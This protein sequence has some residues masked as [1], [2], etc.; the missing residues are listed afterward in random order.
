M[1]SL[2][3]WLLGALWLQVIAPCCPLPHVEQ[4]EVVFPLR[5]PGPRARRALP[6]HWGLYP[7][8]VSYLLKAEEHSFTVHLRKNRE[9]LGSGYMETYSA[10]NGSEVT[11]K[12]Q[13]QDHCLYQG[14]VEGHH[15]SAA[16]LSIC[17][18]LRGFFRVGSAIHLIEPLDESGEEGQHAVYQAKHLQQKSG[19]C[20]VNNTILDSVLGPRVSGAFRPQP[21]PLSQ[22]IHYVELYVVTDSKELQ[23]LGSREAV[24]RR[25]LEVVNHVDKLYQELNFR[26]VLVGLEIWSR[27]KILISPKANITLDNFL[28]WQA[29]ALMGQHLYDNVQLI[30]A[31]KFTGTTVGLAKVSTMCSQYSGAVNEDHHDNPIGVASTMAHEL[32]HNLG[33]NHDENIQGC[34]CPV[35]Q[36]D[37]GCIMAGSIGS[38]F[39]RTFSWC[40]RTDLENF[41][42]GPQVGCLSNAPDVNQ[43]V[44][45][46]V[47]GNLFVERGEQ[48]D[49][50][51]PQHC[52][53]HCC[54]A[55]TCQL[56]EGAECAH[57]DCCHECRVKPAGQP[58][59]SPKDMCDLEESCDGQQPMCPE[60]TFQEN[61]TP[62]PGGYC[63]NGKCPTIAHRCQ[64]LWG[65][66]E[67]ANRCGILY[68][69][70]TQL[71]PDRTSCT[72]STYSGPCQALHTGS[73]GSAFETVLDGTKCDEGKV[74]WEG[75]C[76][77]LQVYRSKNCSA[78]CNNHGVCNHKKECH[79]HA[80]WA[81]PH[82][83]ERLEHVH[84]ASRSLL[85]TIPLVVA[86]LIVILAAVILY[87]K[88]SS[89]F[90]RRSSTP[91]TTVGLSNPV[92]REQGSNLPTKGKIP[93]H[94][95]LIRTTPPS[96]PASPSL[97]PKRPPPAPPATMSTPP[98]PVPVYTQQASD[99]LRPPPPAK[100]LPVLKSKPVTKPTFAPP[101]PPAKPG[102]TQCPGNRDPP[103]PT[104]CPGNGAPA[105]V[106]LFLPSA[107]GLSLASRP[108]RCAN[109]AAAGRAPAPPSERRRARDFRDGGA[110][111]G[112]LRAYG[113][114]RRLPAF[115][116]RAAVGRPRAHSCCERP[117]PPGTRRQGSGQ[118]L[119]LSTCSS[120]VGPSQSWDP[121]EGAW[122]HLARVR[123]LL[124]DK[125]Q[126]LAILQEAVQDQRDP[127][128]FQPEALLIGDP[129]CMKQPFLS[130][131]S[132]AK[133]LAKIPS[134]PDICNDTVEG[135]G[136]EGSAAGLGLPT[137]PVAAAG[138]VQ[139]HAGSR[140]STVIEE[141]LLMGRDGQT[142]PAGHGLREPDQR[143]VVRVDFHELRDAGPTRARGRWSI[144]ASLTH[145]CVVSKV[146]TPTWRSRPPVG[147]AAE[148]GGGPPAGLVQGED[149]TESPSL[150]ASPPLGRSKLGG[151]KAVLITS[152]LSQHVLPGP[153]GTSR[154]C[155]FRAEELAL[156]AWERGGG[157]SIKPRL[158]SGPPHG[159]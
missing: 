30:T 27:D 137:G 139:G 66:G 91:K 155:P 18:G 71:H 68:C 147:A 80:G 19:T 75:H 133:A 146:S 44:G 102:M 140:C 97:T 53:N 126:A 49:C 86:L 22:K 122:E 130:H 123:Q 124:E 83:T 3:L 129:G 96:Q 25:V 26:V 42:K 47:C 87:R 8:S 150:P 131:V 149:N 112:T 107:A 95:E 158:P 89:R 43:L 48:C 35:P 51:E 134:Q 50:G 57:G 152:A 84:K 82:C 52:A 119:N 54:N 136:L 59:R 79:C 23:R 90:Q 138:D 31:V 67:A 105:L 36:T 111:A 5:L 135:L 46:P 17:K 4:Y 29:K 37:G 142:S 121:A 120:Q 153:K 99:Q 77:D 92:F 76:Q 151:P 16:S 64:E 103:L 141:P 143:R 157:G 98:L 69:V 117:R 24:R 159:P 7:E 93:G 115:P 73:S 33:L 20:G 1:L 148:V 9:L 127:L 21:W 114:R 113:H 74:C 10:T 132:P 108:A 60:D 85:F 12:L 15:G 32:G 11:E 145:T 106:A 110:G 65:T 116:R 88:A 72:I 63:F 101:T 40:S 118:T 39:P 61:G 109:S 55:T 70:G 154:T 125:E 104:P 2:N 94:L 28:S 13:E 34:Y 58:C 78:K 14:H 128:Y 156:P 144:E 6:S 41:V 100:L 45:G 81:P 38:K 62:C 56:T